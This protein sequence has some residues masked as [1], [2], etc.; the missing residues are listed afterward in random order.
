MDSDDMDWRR[1]GKPSSTAPPSAAPAKTAA[2]AAVIKPKEPEPARSITPVIKAEDKWDGEDENNDGDNVKDNWDDEDE[3]VPP[4]AADDV[5]KVTAGVKA[6]QV[7]SKKG[8]L[9][10]KLDT[11]AHDE[12]EELTPAEIE[13]YKI[14]EEKAREAE[15]LRL[16]QEAFG[17]ASDK[18]E[19][20]DITNPITKDDFDG[21]RKKLME[22]LGKFSKRSPYQDFL[23]DLIVDLSVCLP[24]KRLKKV[25]TSIEVLYFEKT[26]SEKVKTQPGAGGKGASGKGIKLNVEGDRAILKQRDDDFDDYDDFM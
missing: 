23:E 21:L 5:E 15:E 6:V 10:K 19:F 2:P 22:D 14:R 8:K 26:K 4:P 12:D 20:L 13:A 7:K 3:E 1:P 17:I 18:N 11:R 24:A 9:K 25:K 16:T